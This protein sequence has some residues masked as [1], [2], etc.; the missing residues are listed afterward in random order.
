MAAVVKYPGGVEDVQ[1]IADRPTSATPDPERH[2]LAQA[3]AGAQDWRAWGP[4]LSSRTVP[5]ARSD[6]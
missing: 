2:R 5:H 6:R 1:V 4:Y 3:D